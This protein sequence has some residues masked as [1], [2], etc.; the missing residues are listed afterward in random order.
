MTA[1]PI[2][3]EATGAPSPA[4]RARDAVVVVSHMR[5]GTHLTLDL[6]RR[7]VPELAPRYRNLDQLAPTHGRPIALADFVARFAADRGLPILKTHCTPGL[8]EFAVDSEV[9]AYVEEVIARSRL[10]Y[11]LRDGRD[12]LVSLYHFTQ[13]FDLDVARQSF[14]EFLRGEDRYFRHCKELRGLDRVSAWRRHGELWLAHPQVV[15]VRYAELLR[16]P[17]RAVPRLAEALGLA[18]AESIATVALPKRDLVSR[19]ARKLRQLVDPRNASSS[20]QPGP[21][22][23]GE[24]AR[25]FTVE[26]EAF[27]VERAGAWASHPGGCPE[28]ADHGGWRADRGSGGARG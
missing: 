26:D 19:V 12:V 23:L 4:A 13:S 17:A 10:V 14:S 1:L 28:D 9:H 21:G 6:L 27:F 22:R 3:P 11:V 7:N 16:E 5:S 15:A 8:E 18:P 25:W 20:I 24:G 2:A